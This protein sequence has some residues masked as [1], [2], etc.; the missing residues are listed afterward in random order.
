MDYNKEYA[1]AMLR[2]EEDSLSELAQVEEALKQ[3]NTLDTLSEIA[4]SLID[5]LCVESLSG[6]LSKEQ[7]LETLLVIKVNR[8][9]VKKY[10]GATEKHNTVLG[11]LAE[12][13]N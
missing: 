13:N 12:I 5:K 8:D 11:K 7:M 4:E 10:K 2:Q 9:A 1:I 3:K 6:A